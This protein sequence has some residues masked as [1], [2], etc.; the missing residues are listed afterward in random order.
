MGV[1]Y[2]EPRSVVD[3]TALAAQFGGTASFLAGGTDLVIQMRRGLRHP[4]RLIDLQHIAGLDDI[5]IAPGQIRIGALT[6]HRSIERH[7]C[8]RT[9][10]HALVE[11]AEVIGGCQVRNVGTIGGN[12]CNASP[13][14]DLSPIL[15]VLDAG[16]ELA[17]AH[18]ARTLGLADFLL[19]PGR[20]ARAPDE[21][22]TAIACAAPPP[23]SGTAYIKM[24]RRRAMEIAV[25]SVAALV[26]LAPDGRCQ[27]ARIAV[28]AAAPQALRMPAAEALLR[29]AE[30]TDAALAEAGRLAAAACSPLSD[31]RAS[32]EYRRHLVKVLVPRA[33][34][35]CVERI[36]GDGS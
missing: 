17:G 29:G 28:G 25:V 20:T 23:R 34:R 11:S 24:G 22:M 30:L 36:A 2:F 3:A 5:A 15:L 19:G 14:A 32:A 9:R 35:R 12:L 7:P 31:V 16:V 1:D 21:M 4:A 10:L 8:F 18:G 26:T 33:L 6:R 13:A 27:D